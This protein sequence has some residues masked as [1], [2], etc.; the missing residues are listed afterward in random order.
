MSRSIRNKPGN[1]LRNS[2]RNNKR[3]WYVALTRARHKVY[4]LAD[5][6]RRPPSHTVPADRRTAPG[7]KRSQETP[8]TRR[9]HPITV[10]APQRPSSPSW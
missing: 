9:P 4:I 2:V 3:L 6:S 7:N 10:V 5:D 8:V 1:P